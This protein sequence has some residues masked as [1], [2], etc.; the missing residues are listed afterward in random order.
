[1]TSRVHRLP[2]DLV[3]KIAAGEVV[4]RPASVVKEL[5][6]NALDAGARRIEIEIEHG[7]K[8]LIRVRDDGAGMGADDARLAIE[9]H[10]TSK[11][12]QL[13]DLESLVTHGFRGEALPS[14]ASVS[15]LVLRTCEEGA[16]EG[17]EIEVRHGVLV[18]ARAAGHPRGTTV[19]ARDLF[20]A[21][22]ARRKFLRAD[23]T[24]ASHVAEAVTLASLSRPDV[25]FSLSSGGRRMVDAPPTSGLGPRVF[26]LFGA[27]L[28]DDL[29]AVEGGEGGVRV[30]GLVTRADRPAA[31]RGTLRIY[32]N[33]RAVRDRGLARAVTEAYRL[34]GAGDRRP[35]AFLFVD[36]PPSLV[37][38]N[39]HP[40]KVE[41]RFADARAAWLAV[42]RAVRGALSAGARNAA[43]RADTG[44]IEGGV[45]PMGTPSQRDLLRPQTAVGRYA[46]RL[47][48]GS[49]VAA[50]PRRLDFGRTEPSGDGAAAAAPERPERLILVLGQHRNTYL[51]ASD[52]DELLLVDQHTAHERARYEAI[53]QRL[54]GQAI[55]SQ[56]L[57]SPLVIT[58][59][60]ALR[61][62]LED[63]AEVL[64]ALG[65]DAEPFGGDAVRLASL[66]T[67]LRGRDPATA[68]AALLSD[69]VDREA[70]DWAVSTARERLAATL[71]CHSSVKA[72]Q[73][74]AREAQ[75]AIVSGV[76]AARHP[77][78]CPHGRPTFVRLPREEVTRWFGRVGWRRQ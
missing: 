26:Q 32:V 69:Y 15:H 5:I 50:E 12:R 11:L 38:V 40:A 44:R 23:S 43:P 64:A 17:T 14:I 29:V 2:D 49:A 65:F 16:S 62:A 74:L 59:P 7:G 57:L 54:Q 20:G 10:A 1:M 56:R 55:E 47:A 6:E 78:L 37:D 41:V 71:A 68:V 42:E 70:A 46:E 77:T 3:N 63:Q 52:G 27:A 4:E 39:V 34:A 13:E 60:P 18:H 67:L 36:L 73:P 22:P 72:G 53:L 76:F 31:G 24:E 28:L 8:S 48:D 58:L 21:T 61:V 9:R 66:P 25:G 30:T 19:E 35:E 33:G 51:V 75:Q 45:G